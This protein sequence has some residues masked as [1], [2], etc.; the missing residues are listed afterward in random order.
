MS[1]ENSAVL[2]SNSALRNCSRSFFPVQNTR[3][4]EHSRAEYPWLCYRHRR[5]H[6]ESTG[7]TGTAWSRQT[8]SC[9]QSNR[10]LSGLAG[11]SSFPYLGGT[12]KHRRR[13][14]ETR[15]RKLRARKFAPRDGSRVLV[16]DRAQLRWEV[17]CSD[18]NASRGVATRSHVS[19]MNDLEILL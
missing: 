13:H 4:S 5:P 10:G 14:T 8:R 3:A 9:G 17:A 19:D 16:A 15:G 12:R 7:R 18:S 2:L 11:L 1:A 6:W